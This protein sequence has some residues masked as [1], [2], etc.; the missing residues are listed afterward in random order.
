VRLALSGIAHVDLTKASDVMNRPRL[1]FFSSSLGSSYANGTAAQCHGLLKALAG[2]G[3][4]ITF[5]EPR[6]GIRTSVP[7]AP[8]PAWARAVSYDSEDESDLQRLVDEARQADVVVNAAGDAWLGATL[9]AARRTGQV[10]VYWDAD[11]SATLDRLARNGEARS[12]DLG[13]YDLVVTSGGGPDVVR[14]YESLGV[15]S[16]VPVYNAVDPEAHYPVPPDP[17]FLG[18]LALLASRLP[19]RE[20]RIDEFFLDPARRLPRHRF[21]LGG[22]GWAGKNVP[23]NVDRLGPVHT[24]DHNAFSGTPQ[25]VLHVQRDG[26]ARLG[27][28]PPA[29]LFEAAAAGACLVT[30]PW[31]GAPGF[32]EP[33]AEMIVAGSGEAVAEEIQRLTP[34]R[35]R[36]IGAAARRRVLAGHTY[37][38]R[39]A[40]FERLLGV[41]VAG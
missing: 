21:V 9:L 31:E 12:P 30:D 20:A 25:A 29:R 14:A 36:Q 15:R 16:C 1:A 24:R 40:G 18:D 5:H 19:D 22:Y 34:A 7:V 27:F 6:A 33:G 35:A 39:A 32:F 17:R 28:F 4:T 41:A 26:M 37:H 8:Q 23:P 10:C 2:A 3:W 38:H 13:A 11:P